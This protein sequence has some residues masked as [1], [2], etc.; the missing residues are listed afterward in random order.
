MA[1]LIFETLLTEAIS[2]V[3]YLITK[4]MILEDAINEISNEMELNRME[5][6]ELSIRLKKNPTPKQPVI[7][8]DVEDDSIDIQSSSNS[9]EFADEIEM[10]QALAVLMYKSVPWIRRLGNRLEFADAEIVNKA[11]DALKRRW[12]FIDLEERVVAQINFDNLQD[13]NKVLDFMSSKNMTILKGVLQDLDQDRDLEIEEALVAHKREKKVAKETGQISPAEPSSDMSYKALHRDKRLDA[14][15]LDP[16][17]DKT[18]RI[19][20]V[21]KRW[22]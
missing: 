21:V 15:D 13:Y 18:S 7:E 10:E 20:R 3:K 1:D 19:V 11:H 17:S 14:K 5:N 22:R 16:F 9:I 6:Q 8:D 2:R 4:G 12:D